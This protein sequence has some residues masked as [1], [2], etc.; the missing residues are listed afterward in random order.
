MHKL[1]TDPEEEF[2]EQS[3]VNYG[4]MREALEG[5]YIANVV[6][7]PDGGAVLGIGTHRSALL[8]LEIEIWPE[9]DNNNEIS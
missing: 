2:K 5:E 4:D 1:V 8:P 6:R 7:R 3:P 9:L